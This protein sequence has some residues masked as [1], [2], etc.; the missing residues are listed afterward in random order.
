MEELLDGI[1][2]EL[3]SAVSTETKVALNTLRQYL[4]KPLTPLRRKRF[5]KE[6]DALIES[7]PVLKAAADRYLRKKVP[8]AVAAAEAALEAAQELLAKLKRKK[9]RTWLN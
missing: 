8:A 3:G 1:Q 4:A 2:Q 5:K 9:S 6:C 7:K